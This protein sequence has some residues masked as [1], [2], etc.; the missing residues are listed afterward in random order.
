MPMPFPRI[1]KGMS[2]M[3]KPM[4]RSSCALRLLMAFAL[5]LGMIPQVAF[6]HEDN[7]VT[8][9]RNSL[10]AASIAPASIDEDGVCEIGTGSVSGSAANANPIG[11]NYKNSFTEQIYTADEIGSQG[12]IESISFYV[13]TTNVANEGWPQDSLK[14]Y[15]GHID[16]SINLASSFASPSDITC[17]YEGAPSIGA[18]S[19]AWEEFALSTPFDYNGTDNLLIA[20]AKS[21]STYKSIAYS[22]TTVTPAM[23]AYWRNDS[24]P[25]YVTDFATA[26]DKTTFTASTARANIRM[27]IQTCEHTK[28]SMAETVAPTCT[29]KGYTVYNCATENG[30][31][32]TF[33]DDYMDPLGH[34]MQVTQRATCDEDG[35]RSCSRDC[36]EEGATEVIPARGHDWNWESAAVDSDNPNILTATCKNGATDEYEACTK[37]KTKN[38]K[39]SEWDGSV[40]EGFAGGSGT[41]EDPYLIEEASQ[42]AFLAQQVNRSSSEH[43]TG[44]YFKLTVDL[45]LQDR[46][47]TP[48]GLNK[49]T[50]VSY[51]FGGILDGGGHVISG[52]D[53]SSDDTNVTGGLF[54]AV[55]GTK[56]S[57]AEVKNLI[58]DGRC[59]ITASSGYVGGLCGKANYARFTNIGNHAEVSAS[60]TSSQYAGG[61]VAQGAAAST[62]SI[63]IAGCY[64][65]GAISA[66]TS[67]QYS[68]AYAAGITAF[69]YVTNPNSLVQRCYN[70]GPVAVSGSGSGRAG[71]L[72][73]CVS[74]SYSSTSKLSLANSFNTGQ[75]SCSAKAGSSFYGDLAGSCSGTTASY[76]VTFEAQ[77]CHGTSGQDYMENASVFADCFADC[78]PVEASAMGTAAFLA[79]MNQGLE[80]GDRFLSGAGHPLLPWEGY[81]TP[82]IAG[83]TQ[84]PVTLSLSGASVNA[85]LQINAELPGTG[86]RGSNGSL[87][88]QWYR[89]DAEGN[90]A[91]EIVGANAATY[92]ADFS[93]VGRSYFRCKVSNSFDGQTTDAF[94][95][96][97]CVN[98]VNATPTASAKPVVTTP[99]V[100]KATPAVTLSYASKAYTGKV[101]KPT[102][103]SVKVKG[104]ALAKSSYTVTYPTKSPKAVGT[105]KVKVTLKGAYS[106]TKTVSYKI[107]PKATS[108]SKVTAAKKAFTAKWKK[109]TGTA[110]KQATGYEVRYSTAKSM[111]GAKTKMV[112]G[113]SK[114][115]LKVS[116]LKSAKR[117]YVQVRT[118]KTVGKTKYV[119]AWSK[120]KTVKA[121]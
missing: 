17:V 74:T 68:S 110:A 67:G 20:I 104:K 36:E 56:D 116:K 76:A 97:I 114:T 15:M 65:S 14:I 57:L 19:S 51:Y 54:G 121:R 37:T 55:Y 11:F 27:R 86:R 89:C 40:A 12:S 3:K 82:V 23:A 103:K 88:Y 41:A 13:K 79:S 99:N 30:C 91:E 2:R 16:P 60:G 49:A 9:A 21:A 39:I 85:T 115:S 83:Q 64:N 28:G 7:E 112:K 62:G 63:E 71:G 66:A 105:Y 70:E 33:K 73:G 92:T 45:D 8:A 117:Y 106:G 34:D 44:K 72:V 32:G 35:I 118:Y 61:I 84:S 78:E 113:A 120:A 53:F 29:Q 47:W 26:I 100:T 95:N 48:I 22:L 43:F 5:C 50:T 98:V 111:K 69:S 101:L 25:E 10:R 119:S 77:N 75:V 107:V 80:E 38:I 6:A 108:L 18:T 31:G 90:G 94:G 52:L 109:L 93:T 58:V 87:S 46:P 59:A 102:V 4:R 42:L 96:V 24:N 1:R 81:G